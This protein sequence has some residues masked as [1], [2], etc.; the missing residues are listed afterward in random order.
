MDLQC[1]KRHIYTWEFCLEKLLVMFRDI[2][3]RQ[4]GGGVQGCSWPLSWQRTRDAVE[5]YTGQSFTADFLFQFNM[6]IVCN[7]SNPA[8]DDVF[9]DGGLNQRCCV[10]YHISYIKGE[11]WT[12]VWLLP[13]DHCLSFLNSRGRMSSSCCYFYSLCHSIVFW[14]STTLNIPILSWPATRGHP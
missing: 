14:N 7:L 1:V 2:F 3:V 5:H 13:G 6:S 11:I 4:L 8:L 9:Y 10:S 12:L